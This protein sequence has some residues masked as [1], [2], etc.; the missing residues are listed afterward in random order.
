VLEGSAALTTAEDVE[1][2]RAAVSRR[3]RPAGLDAG[4]SEVREPVGTDYHAL[5]CNLGLT[6]NPD[7]PVASRTARGAEMQAAAVMRGWGG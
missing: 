1:A 2:W 4:L 5:A 7:S 3:S 6:A